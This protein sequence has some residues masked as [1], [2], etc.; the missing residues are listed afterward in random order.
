MTQ[1]ID[2]SRATDLAGRPVLGSRSAF[3]SVSVYHCLGSCSFSLMAYSVPGANQ[4]SAH[5]QIC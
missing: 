1:S 2:L 3:M 5:Q 4:R